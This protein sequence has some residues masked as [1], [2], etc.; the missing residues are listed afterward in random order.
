MQGTAHGF[1]RT[2]SQGRP[3]F[4]GSLLGRAR[5]P[6]A[7]PLALFVEAG[8]VVPFVRERFAIDTV[9][10]VYDPPIVAAATGIGLT[11]DFE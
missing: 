9:G 11:M 7:G 10:V 2:E 8:A 4:A 6:I 1:P 3:L 5:T